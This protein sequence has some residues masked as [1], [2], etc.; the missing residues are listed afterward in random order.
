MDFRDIIRFCGVQLLLKDYWN[1]PIE[2]K[3]KA[4]DECLQ[5]YLALRAMA[6]GV[7]V[8]YKTASVNDLFAALVAIIPEEHYLDTVDQVIHYVLMLAGELQEWPITWWSRDEVA[9]KIVFV[10]NGENGKWSEV[11]TEHDFDRSE[12]FGAVYEM[13]MKYFM[14]KRP[15]GMLRERNRENN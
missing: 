8:D 12:L 5:N 3:K 15:V 7:D 2:E 9:E 4:I 6:L 13:F 1:L 10:W 11:N 14:V